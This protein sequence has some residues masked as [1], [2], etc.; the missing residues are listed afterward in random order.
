[1]ILTFTPPG[2]AGSVVRAEWRD[3]GVVWMVDPRWSGLRCEY[4][5][6]VSETGAGRQCTDHRRH[7]SL[8][9]EFHSSRAGKTATEKESRWRPSSS[10]LASPFSVPRTRMHSPFVILALFGGLTMLSFIL[11]T[12]TRR[13]FSIEKILPSAFAPLRLR[14]TANR[15][16]PGVGKAEGVS[17]QSE[18][19]TAFSL[20][21]ISSRQGGANCLANRGLA[22]R[23]T[24]SK[25]IG[26]PRWPQPHP[27]KTAW[28]QRSQSSDQPP[29][30]RHS[31]V[32]CALARLLS[33]STIS[34]QATGSV[35][36]V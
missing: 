21:G 17:K 20:L 4:G 28:D 3:C 12:R 1:M 11:S 18:V 34:L 36:R 23:T 8:E 24:P 15:G 6:W 27:T 14:I 26:H 31:P 30:L 35:S 9:P 33:S 10:L 32:C 5:I 2:I 16:L 7:R 19:C 25:P 29:G 13:E 22:S